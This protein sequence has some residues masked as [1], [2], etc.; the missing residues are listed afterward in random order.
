MREMDAVLYGRRCLV[1]AV[2][3]VS[4]PN[5]KSRLG[6]SQQQRTEDQFDRERKAAEESERQTESRCMD[7]HVSHG[8]DQHQLQKQRLVDVDTT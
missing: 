7:G 1:H 6:T 3:A 4:R 2:L 5:D 8:H